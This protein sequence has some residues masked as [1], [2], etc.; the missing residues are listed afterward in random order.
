MNRRQFLSGLGVAGVSGLAYAGYKFWPEQGLI[1]PCLSGL[2]NDVLEN[3]L[4]QQIWQ[5]IDAE[6]V[7]DSHVHLVGTGDSQPNEENSSVWF[8][9]NMDSYWHPILKVQKK[10]YM[11][12]TCAANGNIDQSSVQRMAQLTAEMP[13]GFKLMLFAFDWFHDENGKPNQAHSIFHI[14]NEYAAKITSE[15]SQY[16]EWVASIHPYRADAVDALQQ[17]KTQG[18]RAI[19]W[20]PQ[21]MG[22]DPANAKCDTF[23]NACVRLNMPIVCHS[24]RERAVQGSNQDDANPLKLRRAL[25]A[26]VRVVLAHCASDGEDIDYDNG[27]KRIKS[28]DLFLRLMEASQYKNL[29]FGEISAITLMNHAWAIQPLL[30]HTDLH[31]RLLNGSDYP[32]PAILPIVSLKQL[33]SKN[34]LGEGQVDFLKAV[35]LYNPIMF[36]FALKR[37]LRFEGSAFP[38]SVFETRKFF[39]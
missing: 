27:N 4:M 18:A 20:L 6:Q 28:F 33:V 13:T 34:L 39:A 31:S 30:E 7:W 15:H 14:P 25:D 26:G 2:P 36:D 38:A 5:D 29:L 21:G 3:P 1:N 23:Y 17:A 12:G 19:K 37:L 32:L 11:N 16:F 35:R 24:G 22:I 9:P 10:F 8:N